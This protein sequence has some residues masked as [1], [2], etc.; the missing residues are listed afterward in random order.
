M[1]KSHC[2]KWV[3]THI[4]A[5]STQTQTT[6]TV[7]IDAKLEKDGVSCFQTYYWVRNKGQ[8]MGMFGE[9]PLDL[10]TFLQQLIWWKISCHRQQNKTELILQNEQHAKTP[11]PWQWRAISFV[12]G[13]L[14][15]TR[16]N[17]ALSH[18]HKGG[19]TGIWSQHTLVNRFVSKWS[20][21]LG[22]WK[23]RIILQSSFDP[24]PG[25]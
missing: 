3:Y 20:F 12:S 21:L 4:S 14:Q 13:Q 18:H 6:L 22:P 11:N 24:F 9:S 5:K 8:G 23:A 16:P 15:L 17:S 7:G 1:V 10:T 25:S 2:S 19:A